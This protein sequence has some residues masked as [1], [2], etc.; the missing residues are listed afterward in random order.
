MRAC[1][2]ITEGRVSGGDFEGSAIF[3]DSI[4]MAI[5][6]RGVEDLGGLVQIMYLDRGYDWWWWVLSV[7]IPDDSRII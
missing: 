4:E 1:A 3:D 5:V 6:S 2:S 7:G